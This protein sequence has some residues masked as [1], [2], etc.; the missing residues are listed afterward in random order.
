M[1][2]R[3]LRLRRSTDFEIVRKRGRSVSGALVVLAYR[4]NGLEYNRYGFAVGRRV[5]KAVRRNRV[6]RW[7]RE[8][9]RRLHPQLRQG[10]DLVLI[11]RGRLAEPSVTYHHVAGCVQELVRRA[12]LLETTEPAEDKPPVSRPGGHR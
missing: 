12:G 4:P 6:K 11:A 8:A 3:K 10:Y 2:A 5:G 7:L 1:I 9:V